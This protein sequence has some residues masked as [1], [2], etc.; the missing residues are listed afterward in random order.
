M[1][2]EPA[3]EFLDANVLVYALRLLGWAEAGRCP[4]VAGAAVGLR[5]RLPERPG[6]A[7]VL[8]RRH[9]QGRFTAL[10]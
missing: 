3:R 1:T 10:D 6:A 2:A 5:H 8:R 9:A 7:G 4:P